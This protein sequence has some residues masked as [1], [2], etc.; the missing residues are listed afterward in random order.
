MR[1]SLI[2]HAIVFGVLLLNSWTACAQEEHVRY[3]QKLEG[4]GLEFSMEAIPGGRFR[5]GSAVSPHADEKPVHEVEVD[6][7]WMSTFEVT[8][9]IYEPFAYRDVEVRLRLSNTKDLTEEDIDA[10]SK[11]SETDAVTRPSK[12][13]VDMSFGMGKA[14]KPAMAMTQYSAIQFCRWLY[15][16]TGKFYRLPTEAEWEYACRAGT[17]TEYP[18]GNDAAELGEHAWFADNSTSAATEKVGQKKPNAWG[19]YDMLGNASEWTYDQYVADYY[20]QFENSVANNP[21]AVPEKLYPR[22]VRG[23]SYLDKAEDLRSARRMASDPAW[24][25]LDPQIPR[26]KWWLTS[27]P[28]VGIRLVRPKKEPSREEIE[29]YYNKPPIKDF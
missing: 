24:K 1:I 6:P 19:L 11:P 16:R 21:V 14:G 8:W 18:F 3:V 9:D 17:D 15:L 12:P 2:R 27:A 23:G 13:Y 26:S 25:Q 20:E 29:A 10:I 28:F 7:F 22:S 4:T 5:M